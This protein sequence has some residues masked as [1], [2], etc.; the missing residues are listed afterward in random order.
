[1][2]ST[3]ASPPSG[4]NF[5]LALIAALP[6]SRSLRAS[7]PFGFTVSWNVLIPGLILPGVIF[8]AF[9]AYPFLEAWITGGRARRIA[10]LRYSLLHVAKRVLGDRVYERVRSG[11]LGAG[12]S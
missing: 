10:E 1:M 6:R 11:L 8:T 5:T 3:A 4:V 12:R 9:F 7:L 2:E